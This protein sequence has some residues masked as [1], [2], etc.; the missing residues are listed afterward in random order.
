MCSTLV[1]Q[2]EGCKCSYSEMFEGK[3][4]SLQNYSPVIMFSI[5]AEHLLKFYNSRCGFTESQLTCLVKTL[6]L[7]KITSTGH[8]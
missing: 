7:K 4:K 6:I 8:I 5:H 2:K 1:A 3:K